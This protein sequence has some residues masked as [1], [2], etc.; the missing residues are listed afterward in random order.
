MLREF[1]F[2]NSKTISAN[3]LKKRK[4]Q[5]ILKVEVNDAIMQMPYGCVYFMTSHHMLSSS[6]LTIGCSSVNCLSSVDCLSVKDQPIDGNALA[7][8]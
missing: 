5:G 1:S 2:V 3:V 7:N 6:W 8:D 4:C